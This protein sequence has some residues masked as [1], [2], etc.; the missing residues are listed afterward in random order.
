MP[1]F[2]VQVSYTTEAMAAFAK[3]PQDR[4]EVVRKS[5]EK[6]GGSI[7]GAW[8][9]FGEYDVVALLEMP[10]NTSAAAFA[11]AASGGG[12]CKAVKT[13]PL[14]SVEEGLA[15]MKKAGSSGYKGV[16]SK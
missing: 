9:S 5:V 7:E 16:S 8:L 13:T 11:I 10:D 12:A 2:L 4:G 15:A 1:K 3:K 14:L 6:L